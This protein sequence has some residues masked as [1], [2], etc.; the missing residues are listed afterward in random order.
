[1]TEDRVYRVRI[2]ATPEAAWAA[3]T[4]P[5]RTVAW[6]YGSEVPRPAG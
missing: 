5:A 1:M 3:I 4:D 2:D 6:Y